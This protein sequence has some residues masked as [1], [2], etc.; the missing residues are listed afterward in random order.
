VIA[1]TQTIVDIDT[2]M[3]KFFHTF[4]ANLTVKGSHRFDYFAVE[5]EVLK[6]N[7]FLIPDLEYFKP[8]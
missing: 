5:T 6:I 7:I 8:V 3:I 4:A 1:V 2:M